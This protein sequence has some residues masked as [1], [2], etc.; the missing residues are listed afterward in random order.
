MRAIIIDCLNYPT[1]SRN[2]VDDVENY[3]TVQKLKQ[4]VCMMLNAAVDD[5]GTYYHSTQ[6]QRNI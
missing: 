6:I 2:K 3:K 1:A 5:I 4:H